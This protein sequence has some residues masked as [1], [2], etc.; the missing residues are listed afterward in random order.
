MN[1][2]LQ[3]TLHSIYSHTFFFMVK[4]RKITNI[5]NEDHTR[6]QLLTCPHSYHSGFPVIDVSV[7]KCFFRIINCYVFHSLHSWLL[8]ATQ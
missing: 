6:L 3:F 4:R 5:K 8:M 1:E 2:P 7:I